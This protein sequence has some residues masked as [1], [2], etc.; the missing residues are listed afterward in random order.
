MSFRIEQTDPLTLLRE[1]PDDWAQTCITAPRRD[2]PVHYLLAVLDEL[3]RVLR[4]DGTLWLALTRGGNSHEF[5]QAVKDTR[6][7]SPRTTSA[8]PRGV[9]LLTKQSDFLFK[10]PP[11][12]VGVGAPQSPTC[13]YYP[14]AQRPGRG[15]RSCPAP[16]RGWCV[17][18]PGAAGIPPREVIE[19]CI[20]ASTVA[21]ACEVCGTPSRRSVCCREKWRSTCTHKGGRGRCLVIDP[22]CAAG[23]TGMVAVRRGRQ[24]LGIDPSP[25]NAK[26]ARRR[27]AALLEHRR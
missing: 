12:I 10:P 21:C 16:R 23:D 7:V 11:P 13:P 15:C 9:L 26:A 25:A 5:A 6:W 18:S 17:P 20:L 3:H 27:L 22:F 2:A 1:L 8:I 4:H 14:C 19:W 24:Y